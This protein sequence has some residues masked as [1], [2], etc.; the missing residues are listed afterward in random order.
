MNLKKLLKTTALTLAAAMTT[1]LAPLGA[2]AATADVT[3]PVG[4]EQNIDIAS[5]K[6]G[7]VTEF[8]AKNES[9]SGLS[10]WSVGQTLN[11][12]YTDLTLSVVA[13]REGLWEFAYEYK[14]V[15]AG[16]TYTQSGTISVVTERY[17]PP[18]VVT[19]EPVPVE[20]E[21]PVVTPE[22]MPEVT[23]APVVTPLQAHAACAAHHYSPED[24]AGT[25]AGARTR[26]GVRAHRAGHEGVLRVGG[27]AVRH[28]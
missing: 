20:T 8:Y 1:A 13:E 11:G 17:V 24:R 6:E 22:P 27:T 12:A 3:I 4:I 7:E 19:P 16:K 14:Y 15:K 9:G 28:G 18:V 10:S 23:E 2:L 21:E 25:R 26:A 5:V